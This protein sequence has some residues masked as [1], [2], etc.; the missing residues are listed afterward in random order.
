M[1]AHA[2]APTFSFRRVEQLVERLL[3]LAAG[4]GPV[5]AEDKLTN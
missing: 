4:G 5:F 3:H 1:L 2:L